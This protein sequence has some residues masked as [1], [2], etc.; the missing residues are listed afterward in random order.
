[1]TTFTTEDRLEAEKDWKQEYDKLQEDYNDLKDLF[2]KA[3]N[4]WAKD[5]ER[6][7]K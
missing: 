1:M 3:L 6:Q 4:S 7:K 5:M 2:D